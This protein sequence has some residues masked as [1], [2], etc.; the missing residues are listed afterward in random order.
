MKATIQEMQKLLQ[1][2]NKQAMEDYLLSH[3]P[4]SREE[5]ETYE[6]LR[7]KELNLYHK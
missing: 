3:K 5:M 7:N 2:N 1:D 4:E 6:K